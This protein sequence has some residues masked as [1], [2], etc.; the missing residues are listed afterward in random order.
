MKMKTKPL[1]RTLEK[2][3]RKRLLQMRM[4]TLTRE[5]VLEK[6]MMWRMMMKTCD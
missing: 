1:E 5:K 2:T 6:M 4:K 3:S